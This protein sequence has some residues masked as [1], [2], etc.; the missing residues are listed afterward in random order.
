MLVASILSAIA[1]PV[2]LPFGTVLVLPKGSWGSYSVAA[3]NDN[4]FGEFVPSEGFY[5]PPVTNGTVQYVPD[6][7]SGH[8]G[9]T[10]QTDA[11]GSLLKTT[12][13]GL[14]LSAVWR[15]KP[16]GYVRTMPGYAT[17][18]YREYTWPKEA[19]LTVECDGGTFFVKV[20]GSPS[21]CL[22]V[23]GDGNDVTVDLVQGQQSNLIQDLASLRLRGNG[24]TARGAAEGEMCAAFV[25]GKDNRLLDFTA[26]SRGI[27]DDTGAVYV[28]GGS[29]GFRS[30]NLTVYLK[31]SEYPSTWMRNG[32][33]LDDEASDCVLFNTTVLGQFTNAVFVHGGDDNRIDRLR[34][35]GPSATVKIEPFFRTPTVTPVG[36]VVRSVKAG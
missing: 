33:Y 24:N 31:S 10:L 11:K 23:V 4:A 18:R 16:N 22:E 14:D 9:A 15:N 6:G 25:D 21:M 7:A 29:H 19:A 12:F 26:V 2:A 34:S 35:F 8:H 36:N 20:T 3:P 27:G 1:L 17:G 32:V 28:K 13:D 30:T 5:F